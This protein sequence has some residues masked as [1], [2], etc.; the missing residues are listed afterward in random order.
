MLTKS[1]YQSVSFE[2]E[3]TNSAGDLGAAASVSFQNRNMFKGSETF[4]IKLRGA[5]EAVSGLQGGY[6]HEDYTELGRK[7]RSTF[8]G[9]SFRFFPTTSGGRYVL[10][11]NLAYSIIIRYVRSF[12]ASLLLPIGVTNGDCNVSVLS[13]A[14]ICWISTT[15]ICL[16]FRRSS[17]TNI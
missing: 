6:N 8:R 11:R 10:L 7:Q 15:C 16:P 14:L 2:L 13:I 3:G 12:H 9:F 17:A 5:Y 4:M 1:K